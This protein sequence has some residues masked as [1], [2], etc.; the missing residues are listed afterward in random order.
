[1]ANKKSLL[2]TILKVVFGILGAIVVIAVGGYCYLK[3]ALGIDI[4]DITKK[5]NLISNPVSESEIISNPFEKED[6]VEVL[7]TMF[8]TNNIVSQEGN[9]Y[10]FNLEAFVQ[11]DM[12]ADTI[13]S[14]NEIAS[15]LALFI[16]GVDANSSGIDNDLAGYITLKQISFSNFVSLTDEISFDINYVF[17]TD[18]TSVKQ[19]A[20]K[21]NAII[22]FLVNKFLPDKIYF[23]SIFNIQLSKENYQNYAITNGSFVLNKLNQEQTNSILDVFSIISNEDLKTTLPT[24]INTM[25]CNTLFGGNGNKGLLGNI[26]DV[27]SIEFIE[28][29]SNIKIFIK[30]V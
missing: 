10:N 3:F 5:L 13:L 21:E 15:L 6:G 12:Q 23:N 19:E 7:S 14:D 30:K 16:E 8:G 11:A 1:M 4:I 9:K 22:G 17:V 27:S 25:F 26:K 18:L 29:N 24:K 20:S 28:E 2:G